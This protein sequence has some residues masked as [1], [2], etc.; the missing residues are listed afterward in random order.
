MKDLFIIFTFMNPYSDRITQ[1]QQTIAQA[2]LCSPHP[3]TAVRLLA[4]SKT[5]P[6]RDI[7]FAYQAGLRHFGESYLQEA[8][9]KQKK[10]AHFAITWHFIGPIQSNKTRAIANN[11]SWVHS[12]DRVKIAKR[13]HEQRA[14]TLPPL[15]IFLQVNISGEASKSGVT[16]EQLPPLVSEI[17]QFKNLLLRG[18]MAV[19]EKQADF[20]TQCRPYRDIYQTVQRLEDPTL[21]HFSFG[22]S[23]DIKAAVHEGATIVRVGTALF[24]QR[25][26]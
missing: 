19:P 12:V 8:L 7:C 22:M 17:K 25:N 3:E 9:S 13:L 24:G 20:E 5:K 15:N 23:G 1:I 6:S 11:F 10:L 26:Y 14:P 4:V 2:N 21:N 16:L 18:I